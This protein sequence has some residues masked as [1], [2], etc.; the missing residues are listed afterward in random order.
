MQ[1]DTEGSIRELELVL[2]YSPV[3][4]DVMLR[5]VR[6]YS[7]AQP[8]RFSEAT[9]VLDGGLQNPR[10]SHDVDLLTAAAKLVA[11][12]GNFPQ[13]LALIDAARQSKPDDRELEHVELKI[14]LSARGNAYEAIRRQ[15]DNDLKVLTAAPWW[16]YETRGL[17]RNHLSD[18]NGAM[19]DLTQALALA[20]QSGDLSAVTT[21]DD[22]I[23]HELDIDETIASLAGQNT[24]DIRWQLT[25]AQLYMLKGD[26]V[27]AMSRMDQIIGNLG[28]LAEEQQ[29]GALRAADLMYTTVI[30]PLTDR[31]A[32]V[33]RKLLKLRPADIQTLNNLANR[34]VELNP[35]AGAVDE[36]LGY[37]QRAVD[38]MKKALIS[39]P[40][41]LETYGWVQ[42]LAG[43]GAQGITTL[44]GVVD[45]SPSPEACYHLSEAYM[46]SS[47]PQRALDVIYQAED[48][49]AQAGPQN[50]V[51][52]ALKTRIDDLK[53]RCEAAVLKRGV[54]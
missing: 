47:Y 29:V 37:S 20:T 3:D 44:R 7:S 17:A 15:V 31:A 51:S 53:S 34:I 24:D 36:A 5:L 30:P 8:P 4:K 43:H 11:D 33:E 28:S 35:S 45:S 32:D 54:Q 39:D 19:A 40:A 46:R 21:V 16:M 23:K 48:L 50:S 38:E 14:E 49:I 10:F 25:T 1:H 26:S 9:T 6:L 52:P 13:A 22:D 27:K 12:Q 41:V 42:V 2:H 18:R